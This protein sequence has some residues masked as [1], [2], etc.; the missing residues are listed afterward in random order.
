[1][2]RLLFLIVLLVPTTGMADGSL[3]ED[4]LQI[5]RSWEHANFELSGTEKIEG[6]ER[7]A[8]AADRLVERWPGRA[9][10]L[11]WKGITYATW[12]GARGGPGALGLARRA[13][14]ALLAAERIDPGVMNGA[15]YT[16]LGSIY[17]RVPGWPIGFGDDD[18][19]AEY[20]RKAMQMNPD[21]LNSNYFYGDFLL[22]QRQYRKAVEVLRRALRAQPDPEHPIADRGRRRQV[23][24]ALKKA[25]DHVG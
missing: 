9:E 4:V 17:Y 10:P 7:V 18:K 24:A 23:E 25:L 19:A 2:Q 6:L 1:M 22:D 14:D 15:I 11:L 20:F 3:E 13:R 5:H 21:G 12:A 16:T 8:H